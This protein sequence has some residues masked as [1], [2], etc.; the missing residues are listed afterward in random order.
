ME[1]VQITENSKL[2]KVKK[3]RKIASKSPQSPSLFKTIAFKAAFP[4]EILVYQKLINK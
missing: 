1:R 4:A 2:R 3:I